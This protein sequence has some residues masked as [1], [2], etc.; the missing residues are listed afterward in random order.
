ML[1]LSGYLDADAIITALPVTTKEGAIRAL[2][3]KLFAR[4]QLLNS[5]VSESEACEAVLNREQL[6]ST[7]I[8][9]ALAFPHARIPGWGAFAV[10]AAACEEGLEFG[11]IDGKPVRCIFLMISSPDEPYIILQTMSAI[12]RA[13]TDYNSHESRTGQGVNYAELLQTFS[14]SSIKASKH[15]LAKDIARP[16]E[17]CVELTTSLETVTHMMHFKRES[18][19]PVVDRNNRLCGEISCYC[20]FD[21]GMP[22]F[23]K[24][25]N[26]ISFVRHIDPF[27]K[28]FRLQK[29]LTV[30]D[31]LIKDIHP[32]Q[33]DATIAEIVFE[34]TVKRK[35]KLF[36]VNRAGELTGVIDRFSIVD[37]ILFF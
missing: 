17:N 24:Q 7:G 9:K 14:G 25:L 26:T 10:A 31:V 22:D 16:V 18:L 1:D 20:I 30:Q 19:L 27:E 4:Q 11:S 37:Q 15:L 3:Q 35:S 8:G 21:Y 12:I 28:Y 23:F 6:Q 36:M 33:E 34:M 32:V 13:I 29:S 2:V 5:A